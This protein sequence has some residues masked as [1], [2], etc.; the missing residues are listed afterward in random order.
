[1]FG[2]NSLKDTGNI[3]SRFKHDLKNAFS[4]IKGEMDEH[5]DSINANTSEISSNHEY[6]CELESKIDKL[7]ERIEDL[8]L[9]LDA[10][11]KKSEFRVRTLTRKEQEVFLV[12]YT[13]EQDQK[14]VT[15]S[16][17]GQ[18]LGINEYMVQ[19]HITLLI[20][21]GIPIHKNFSD[22]IVYLRLDPYFRELQAKK[23]IANV[24]SL[25]L[26]KISNI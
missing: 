23:N 15:Y 18:F 12:L 3:F 6:S 17:I 25:V 21:K 13:L 8:E 7:N 19:D 2:G 20:A 1:M 26:K 22:K 24:N 14:P 9:Q 4:S 11:H 10:A 5:L 16:R